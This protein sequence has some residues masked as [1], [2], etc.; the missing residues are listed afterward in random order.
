MCYSSEIEVW[1]SSK[2]HDVLPVATCNQR[3]FDE[4][5]IT[6]P[7]KSSAKLHVEYKPRFLRPTEAT[8]YAVELRSGT[9]QGKTLAFALSGMVNSVG[10]E[11][12]TVVHAACYETKKLELNVENPY[13]QSGNFKVTIVESRQDVFS[14]LCFLRGVE[15]Q[16]SPPQTGNQMDKRS[17]SSLGYETGSDTDR[18]HPQEDDFPGSAEADGAMQ[19]FFCKEQVIHLVGANSCGYDPSK[20]HQ[21]GQTLVDVNS[22]EVQSVNVTFIPLHLGTRNC[23]LLFSNDEIGEFVIIVRGITGLPNPSSIP[24]TYDLKT[25]PFVSHRLNSGVAAALFG[26]PDDNVMYLRIPVGRSV[27]ETLMIPMENE[28]RKEATLSAIRLRL[29]AA[30][31]HRREVSSTLNSEDLL[32]LANQLLLLP[33]TR[34]ERLNKD[35]KKQSSRMTKKEVYR[36]TTDAPF[37]TCPQAVETKSN[38]I[39]AAGKSYFPLDVDILIRQTGL[40]SARIIVRRLDDIRVYHLKCVAVPDNQ[41]F[42]LNFSAPLAQTITQ[43]IPIVNKSTYDWE[44]HAKF[45]GAAAWF[46]GPAQ[47]SVPA[48]NTV[49]YPVNFV[50]RRETEVEAGLEL[51]NVTDG[52]SHKYI[53]NG[54]GLKPFSSGL[55]R[56]NCAVGGCGIGEEED[57]MSMKIAGAKFHPFTVRVPNPTSKKQS[58]RLGTDLPMGTIYWLKS[59]PTKRLDVYPGSVEECVLYFRVTRRGEFSGVIAFVA[60]DEDDVLSDEIIA[61]AAHRKQG[62][63][64][65]ENQ[66]FQFDTSA[67][68]LAAQQINRLGAAFRVWY[69]VQ[70]IVEPGP[71]MRTLEITCPCM[72]SQVIEIPFSWPHGLPETVNKLEL[73]VTLRGKGIVGLPTHLVTKSADPECPVYRLEYWPS[74]VESSEG[75]IAFYHQDCGEFW[76]A[77]KLAGTRPRTVWVPPIECELGKSKVTSLV[78]SN[79]TGESYILQPQLTNCEVFMLHMGVTTKQLARISSR[80]SSR[81]GKQ[82]VLDSA[83]SQHSPTCKEDDF[84]TS[85]MNYDE[86][87]AGYNTSRD[88]TCMNVFLEA[89]STLRLGVK[90][91]PCDIGEQAH[92]GEITFYSNKLQK[93]TFLLRGIGLPPQPRDPL[94][95]HAALGAATTTMLA[96]PNPFKSPVTVDIYFKEQAVIKFEESERGFLEGERMRTQ[97]V[98]LTEGSVQSSDNTRN[99]ATTSDSFKLLLESDR[100][101]SLKSK[102][103]LQVPVLFAPTEMREYRSVCTVVMRTL[104]SP[105][106]EED[107]VGITWLLPIKGVPEASSSSRLSNRPH[108]VQ[109]YTRGKLSEAQF[110]PTI[111]GVA[112]SVSRY[113][114]HVTLSPLSLTSKTLGP[115]NN[116]IPSKDSVSPIRIR[117]VNSIGN[118]ASSPDQPLGEDSCTEIGAN[119]EL[120][121]RK[122]SDNYSWSLRIISLKKSRKI[123]E[124]YNGDRLLAKSI[125]IRLKKTKVKADL[126]INE[127]LFMAK[128]KPPH[129]FKCNAELAIKSKSGAVWSFD[130]SVE[131]RRPQTDDVIFMPINCLWRTVKAKLIL[132]SQDREPKPFRAWIYPVN[133]KEFK[134]EPEMGVL[135]AAPDKIPAGHDDKD[136]LYRVPACVTLSFTPSQYE[137]PRVARLVVQTSEMEWNYKIIGGIPAYSVP[138]KPSHPTTTTVSQAVSKAALNIRTKCNYILHNRN[139]AWQK[140]ILRCAVRENKST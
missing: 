121:C 94:C 115:I 4:L 36:T 77:L 105:K 97:N 96:V 25:A 58:Y 81:I 46:S 53:L 8:L 32:D 66:L 33:R 52:S 103:V 104:R 122:K 95:I 43:P 130:I 37:V 47:F 12:A 22:D 78:L 10:N 138:D 40:F 69:E 50:A 119:S 75:S 129:P 2:R 135:P 65:A 126:G 102:A 11:P 64:G 88:T 114:I 116:A 56:L 108:L 54:V 123:D 127:L 74:S 72:D 79:P 139:T 112:R 134:V 101:L 118:R 60:E 41:Q 70:M 111:T 67:G 31:L 99:E 98:H 124:P 18:S 106:M 128:F 42:R 28:A 5:R 35:K 3:G 29:T 62:T 38:I 140:P 110:V 73:D 48:E 90:F 26:Q 9:G 55:I 15:Y 51:L 61:T 63:R 109:K 82:S 24:I 85:P 30:E 7:A 80:H 89:E 19:S 92:E 83:R 87:T 131:A 23:C 13:A 49:N 117:S 45:T 17:T 21:E 137:K 86:Q 76:I 71:P 84:E 125:D 68:T 16:Q 20:R 113:H 6:V 133:H 132:T 120:G 57:P 34:L 39:L 59:P 91:T 136:S 1:S 27:R 107:S 44:L 14:A 100:E 93:W